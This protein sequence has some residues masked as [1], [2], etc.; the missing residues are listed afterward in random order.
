MFNVADAFRKVGR[1]KR[2]GNKR[3]RFPESG[4]ILGIRL[5]KEARF[6][7]RTIYQKRGRGGFTRPNK[8]EKVFLA[9]SKK[10]EQDTATTRKQGVKRREVEVREGR[11]LAL[12][13]GLDYIDRR[14]G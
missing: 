11:G 3:K 7:V 9:K 6:H 10:K 5:T 1:G 8:L 12:P 14:K 13:L 4:K 2:E